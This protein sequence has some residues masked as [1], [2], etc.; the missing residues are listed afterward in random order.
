MIA[1][2][3]LFEIRVMA[4]VYFAILVLMMVPAVLVWADLYA[5]FQRGSAMA[6]ALGSMGDFMKR[7]ISAMGSRDEDFA[8]LSY[9][10][11]QLF[12]KGANVAGIA[13]AVLLGTGLFAREREAMTLEFLLSRPISRSRI[14]W[15]KVWPCLLAI[16]VPIFVANWL[17]IP[18]SHKQGY[19]LP[20]GAV[21]WS[22]LHASLFAIDVFLLQTIA[23]LRSRVQANAAFWVG[24][25]VIVQL[26][27]YFIP[28]LRLGSMFRLADFDWYGPILAGNRAPT[29]MFDLV[30]HSGLTSWL[31]LAAVALYG[32]ALWLLRRLEL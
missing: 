27:I 26:A 1:R 16:A 10:A 32:T 23:S 30:H 15:Q 2:K 4:L 22:S 25:F 21:T 8:F 19:T 11:L 13:A 14:L 5:D 17:A 6:K 20:F 3:T 9:M 7:A 12:F 24:G 28:V 18:V 31:A 29:Q